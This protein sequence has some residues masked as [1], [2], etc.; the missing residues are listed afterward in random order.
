MAD[1]YIKKEE[2]CQVNDLI[3]Y[4]KELGKEQANLQVRDDENL[5]RTA[6]VGMK[7]KGQ[8][9]KKYWQDLWQVGF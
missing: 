8:I 9:W 6:V 1:T 5:N 2:S 3:L 4:L 7:R